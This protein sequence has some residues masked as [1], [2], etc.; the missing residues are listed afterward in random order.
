[1]AKF[2]SFPRDIRDFEEIARQSR[3]RDEMNGGVK[4][5]CCRDMGTIHPFAVREY[6][7]DGYDPNLDPPLRCH[8]CESLYIE[9]DIPVATDYKKGRDRDD[10]GEPQGQ[11]TRK[12]LPRFAVAYLDN[13]ADYK[14]CERIHRAEQQRLQEGRSFDWMQGAEGIESPVKPAEIVGAIAQMT[15][16]SNAVRGADGLKPI[17]PWDQIAAA[18]GVK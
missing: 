11:V 2:D 3:E 15:G 9:V 14:I 17:N 6:L 4:C 1:M 13:R 10:D 8:R 12:R 5:L 16:P 7:I 18:A